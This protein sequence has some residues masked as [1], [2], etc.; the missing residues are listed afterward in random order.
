MKYITVL[1]ASLLLSNNCIS[2]SINSNKLK[3]GFQLGVGTYDMAELK[4]FNNEILHSLPFNAKIN[5]EFPPYLTFKGSLLYQFKNYSIGPAIRFQSTGARIS[6]QDYTGTY[7]LDTK[8]AGTDYG[9]VNNFKFWSFPTSSLNASATIGIINSKV[10]FNE[11]LKLD[12][13]TITDESNKFEFS[14]YY[15]EP[16]LSYDKKISSH[17]CCS[18]DIAYMFQFGDKT[19]I[20]EETG[21]EGTKLAP[22]WNGFRFGISLVLGLNE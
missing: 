22:K 2:Q 13:K 18:A 19:F 8:V 4:S 20:K 17:L 11:L 12:G 6:S 10:E 21:Y 5:E 14:N 15:F 16:G 3:V 9:I 1:I 7:K